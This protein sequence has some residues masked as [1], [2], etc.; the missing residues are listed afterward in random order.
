MSR[1][2]SWYSRYIQLLI[3]FAS[4]NEE[5]GA[6]AGE[7]LGQL[8]ALN[9]KK[10]GATQLFPRFQGAFSSRL[11]SR[12][13]DEQVSTWRWLNSLASC[14]PSERGRVLAIPIRSQYLGTGRQN[15]RRVG[16]SVGL[17]ELTI[18]R[19]IFAPKPLFVI[20]LY[21]PQCY[22]AALLRAMETALNVELLWAVGGVHS[23]RQYCMSV[24]S[25][26]T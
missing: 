24:A 6:Q 10:T 2:V 16:P 26:V 23:A 15:V 4:C 3:H 9:H 13:R 12:T 5:W 14:G 19:E 7:C 17:L 25:L 11:D 1:H 21:R 18:S 20:F 8:F 22:I